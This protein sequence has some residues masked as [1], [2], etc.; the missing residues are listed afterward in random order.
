MRIIPGEPAPAEQ[1]TSYHP[2]ADFMPN[3]ESR[4]REPLISLIVCTRN[5]AMQL[6]N[7][8]AAIGQLRADFQWDLIVVDNGSTDHTKQVIEQF[9]VGG[10]RA[11]YVLERRPGLSN[12]RNAGLA[13]AQG[14]IIAFTDDDCY[15]Q[16]DFLEQIKKAF[17]D[18]TL[19]FLT[20]RIMLHDPTDYP[21]TINESREPM[22][23]PPHSFIYAGMVRGANMAFRRAALRQIDG[24]D[25]LFGSGAPFPAEDCD[26]AA[27]VSL[28]G[29]RGQYD[30]SVVVSHHHGRKAADIASLLRAYDIGRGAYHAKLLYEKRGFLYALRGWA[31]LARRALSRPASIYWELRGAAH[32]VWLRPFGT[33]R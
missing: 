5:R 15:P 28:Q 8:L 2:A 22:D 25:P 30:P 20:G 21:A 17:D 29:W 26:A 11:H 18:E 3:P 32:Y 4:S 7:C 13:C 19:G 31:G 12:A 6:E 33:S 27:R 9:T 24:F 1:P 23:I 14:D 16:A 10:S